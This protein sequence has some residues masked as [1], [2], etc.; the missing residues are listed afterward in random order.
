MMLYKARK[1][2]FRVL[3]EDHFNLSA[4]DTA[5]KAL[6]H[7]ILENVRTGAGEMVQRWEHLNRQH[8]YAEFW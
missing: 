7:Q 2:R 4:L 5:S 6:S 1:L 3:T 8:A